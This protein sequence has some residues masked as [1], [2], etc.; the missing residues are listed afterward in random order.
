MILSLLLVLTACQEVASS[1]AKTENSEETADKQQSTIIIDGLAKHYHTGDEIELS[2]HLSVKGDNENWNWYIKKSEIDQWETIKGLESDV[3]SREATINGLKIKA[4]IKNDDGKITYESDVVEV[5]IDDHHGNDEETRRIYNGFFYNTEIE[6]RTLSDWEGKWQS[7]KPYLQSG[8][9]DPVFESK[10]SEDETMTFAEY[11]DYY[12]VGYETDVAEIIIE[13]DRFT[14]LYEDGKESE[15]EYA[16]EG[17]E[18]LVYEKGN[19]GVRYIFART[20][21]SDAMP[22]YIQFSDHMISPG[23]SDHFHLYWGNDRQTLL[24]EVTHWPTYYPSEMDAAGL[25]RDM[26]AH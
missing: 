21:E 26:L 5:V 10:A 19:R 22:Q 16:Y 6:D 15:A 18:T 2:A 3:F 13:N 20:G 14:F 24:D 17:F 9:L 7:V 4:A 8:D 12:A 25:V 1:P 23:K 11:K